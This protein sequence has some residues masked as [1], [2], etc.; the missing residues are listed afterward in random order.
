MQFTFTIYYL[1]DINHKAV[2]IFSRD[3]VVAA[4]SK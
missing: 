1:R 2:H 3:S 4:Q